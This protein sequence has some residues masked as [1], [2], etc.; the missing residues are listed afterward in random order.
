MDETILYSTKLSIFAFTV[1]DLVSKIFVHK[2]QNPVFLFYLP[3]LLSPH[4]RICLAM[5]TNMLMILSNNFYMNNFLIQR[6]AI[7]VLFHTYETLGIR[8][9]SYADRPV[10][11]LF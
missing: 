5:H 4:K 11:E 2:K 7:D 9:Q 6:T 8:K 1:L 3:Q 10:H